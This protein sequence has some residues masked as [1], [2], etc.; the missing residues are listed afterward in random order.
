MS[1]I[2]EHLELLLSEAGDSHLTPEEQSEIQRLCATNEDA[3][4]QLHQYARLARLLAN[5]RPLPTD[6]DLAGTGGKLSAQLSTDYARSEVS[7]SEI[8]KGYR[9]LPDVDWGSFQTRISD[10]IRSDAAITHAPDSPNRRPKRWRLFAGIGTPLAAAAAVLLAVFWQGTHSELTPVG[11]NGGPTSIAI[12]LAT[13]GASGKI[14]FK[15][16]DTAKSAADT[17]SVSDLPGSAIAIG[18]GAANAAEMPESAFLF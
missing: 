14:K 7:L 2:P 3:A 18:P 6:L 12:H 1:S 11:I 8:L 15:F 16:D 9:Q 5:W 17:D 13:P 10:S 4:K